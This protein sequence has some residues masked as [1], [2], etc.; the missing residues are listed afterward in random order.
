MIKGAGQQLD[1]TANVT[2]MYKTRF[3][4]GAEEPLGSPYRDENINRKG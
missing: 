3:F 4:V 2:S 1:G